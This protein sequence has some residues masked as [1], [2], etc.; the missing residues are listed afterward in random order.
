MLKIAVLRR[1]PNIRNLSIGSAIRARGD[2]PV[3]VRKLTAK[4]FTVAQLVTT[5]GLKMFFDSTNV[6]AVSDHSETGAPVTCVFGISQNPLEITES[7]QSFLDRISVT[8]NFA[9]LSRPDGAQIWIDS[10]AV[11]SLRAA[12]P[13]EYTTSVKSVI[14]VGNTVLG[15]CEDV[16]MAVEAINAHGGKL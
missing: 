13:G 6:S 12:I 3:C 16:G 14:T 15:V 5:G 7:V 11:G 1:D 4:R 10:T 2:A 8:K 9:K